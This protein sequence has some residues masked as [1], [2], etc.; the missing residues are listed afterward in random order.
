ML[1]EIVFDTWY[2]RRVI[3]M[4]DGMPCTVELLELS[5]TPEHKLSLHR[6]IQYSLLHTLSIGSMLQ[7]KEWFYWACMQKG[8]LT[9]RVSSEP[10][11]WLRCHDGDS[12]CSYTS[13]LDQHA[14]VCWCEGYGESLDRVSCRGPPCR[15]GGIPFEP[16][17]QKDRWKGMVKNARSHRVTQRRLQHLAHAYPWISYCRT[18]CRWSR[19]HTWSVCLVGFNA[20][21]STR[22]SPHDT[23]L[24][25]CPWSKTL[26]NLRQCKEQVEN[27]KIMAPVTV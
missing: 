14:E 17:V 11:W 2:H 4:G 8:T 23:R 19:A 13:K 15:R 1:E 26:V 3:L 25:S 24:P 7:G 12:W 27:V 22:V 20:K 18:G 21:L 10:H 16:S 5:L 6:Y 9:T